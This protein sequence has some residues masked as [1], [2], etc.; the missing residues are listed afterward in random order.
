MI[1][2]IQS[3]KKHLKEGFSSQS[4]LDKLTPNIEKLVD[5]LKRKYPK[6][7]IVIIDNY[8][9][10]GR[11]DLKGTYTLSA[12]ILDDSFDF[13]PLKNDIDKIRKLSQNK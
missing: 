4:K 9:W 12:S 6:V 8:K 1:E 7:N 3:F 11:G 5:K 13:K 10:L 2:Q